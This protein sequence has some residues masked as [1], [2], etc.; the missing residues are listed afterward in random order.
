M[1]P[2]EVK[3]ENIMRKLNKAWKYFSTEHNRNHV[4]IH[5]SYITSTPEASYKDYALQ[6][7]TRHCQSV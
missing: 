6:K 1:A 2:M 4:K 3:N 7:E 5:Q